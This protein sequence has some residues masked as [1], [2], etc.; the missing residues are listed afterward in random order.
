MASPASSELRATAAVLA[1]FD[2]DGTLTRRD[3]LL[4]YLVGFLAP[5][6]A[7]WLRLLS[8][9]AAVASFAVG[10]S[11]RDRC[12]EHIVRACLGG[13]NRDELGQHTQ[14]FVTRLL[15][16]GMHS[17]ALAV[18]E[19]HRAGGARLVLLSASADLYVREIATRLGFHECIC[20]ELSWDGQR[21][22][23]TFASANRRGE[24]KSV[25]VRAIRARTSGSIAAYGNA[26]SD[27]PHLELTDYPLLVNG[28]AGARALALAR[29]IP[30]ELWR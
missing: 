30:C 14:R 3:T 23:G 28:S 27:L 17:R 9:V 18:L 10:R 26:S 24:E 1:I 2:L 22:I 4:P 29:G 7:R 6:P 11:D 25:V 5:R 16:R 15:E 13:A 21:L 19:A 20:T 12:K 8:V